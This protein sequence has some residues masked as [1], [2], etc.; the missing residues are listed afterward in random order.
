MVNSLYLKALLLEQGL[1]QKEFAKMLNI[2]TTSLNKKLNNVVE[3]KASEII[4]ICEILNN[5]EY[6]KIFQ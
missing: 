4:K 1:T 5:V 6:S 2:S 3:F